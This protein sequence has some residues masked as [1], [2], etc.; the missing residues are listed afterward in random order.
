MNNCSTPD[1]PNSYLEHR[2]MRVDAARSAGLVAA[3]RPDGSARRHRAARRCAGYDS[4]THD[5]HRTEGVV[6]C[7]ALLQQHHA[8]RVVTARKVVVDTH[9]G[10]EA[11]ALPR[12]G[13]VFTGAA[14]DAAH[15][16]WEV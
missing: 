4:A 15:A 16:R 6:V 8:A 14:F 11:I 9:R 1:L 2:A 13:A 10:D 3:A 12:F 7:P 5:E